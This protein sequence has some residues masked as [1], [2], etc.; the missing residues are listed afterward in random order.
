VKRPICKSPEKMGIGVK[1]GLMAAKGTRAQG[2]KSTSRTCLQACDQHCKPEGLPYKGGIL[3]SLDGKVAPR[4]ILGGIG[5]EIK[6][7]PVEH[8]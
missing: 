8:P 5:R 6:P 1:L 4:F 3:P 2:H 7:C